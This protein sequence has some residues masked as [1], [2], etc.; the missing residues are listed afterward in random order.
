[1][2]AKGKEEGRSKKIRLSEPVDGESAIRTEK[3]LEARFD[4]NTARSSLP[5][6]ERGKTAQAKSS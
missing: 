2:L 5:S 4:K 6:W 3:N 1:L